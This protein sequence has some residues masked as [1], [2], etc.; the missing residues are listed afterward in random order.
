MTEEALNDVFNYTPDGETLRRFMLSSTF[1]R[2][3]RGP[4][5]SGKSAMCCV[6]MF[7]RACQQL[8][9]KNG[10]RRTRWGVIRN[11][12]PQLKT[13]TIKTWLEWFPEHIFGKFIFSP[14]F[15][16]HIK[17]PL[18]DGTRLDMEVYF[19]AMDNEQ[20]VDNLY[21]LELTGG[22]VNEARFVPKEVIDGL[23]GRVGRYP[24]MKDGGPTWSGVLLDTNSPAEEHWW[25]VMSGD[26]PAPEW[27]SDEDKL[28]LVKPDNWE[29]YTQPPGMVEIFDDKGKIIGYEE[30]RGQVEGIPKAE[31]LNNLPPD[32][33]KNT[34]QGKARKWIEVNILNRYGSSFE[35]RPVFPSFSPEFHVSSE[36]L[37][38]IEGEDVWVGIDFGRTPAAIF[39]QRRSLRWFVQYELVTTHMGTEAFSK[40]FKAFIAEKYPVDARFKIFGDPSGDVQ[41]QTRDETPFMILQANGINAFPAP[42]NDPDIRVEAVESVLNRVEDGQ[43]CLQISSTCSVLKAGMEGGYHYRKLK[44]NHG[45]MYSPEPTK[46]RFSHPCE[47]FEYLLCGAGESTRVVTGGHTPQPVIAPRATRLVGNRGQALSGRTWGRRR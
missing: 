13:T 16:H 29:F 35:G 20:D 21:S 34:I 31:N 10:V 18:A 24:A 17:V 30:N 28:T 1:L 46:N 9:D 7:R 26:K 5:G 6:E 4:W 23:T 15:R 38:Y 8:P 39:A 32:Y 45:D 40:V 42:T 11:T 37:L 44:V 25:P 47:A 14:P 22:W 27:M 33:Y 41:A 2:A 43:S 3:I 12:G 19:L 36:P